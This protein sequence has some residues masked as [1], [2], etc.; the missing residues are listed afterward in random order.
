MNIFTPEAFQIAKGHLSDHMLS[1]VLTAI[2]QDGYAIIENI[3]NCKYLDQIGQQ[4]DEDSTILIAKKQWG[5]AGKI[6]GH[7][8]QGPP[9]HAPY[10]VE[11]VVAN[12]F[13]IQVAKCLLG[14][15]A[16]NAFYNG[17]TN[18]PGS[19]IQPLHRDGPI[20]WANMTKPHPTASI[21]V[22]ISPRDTNEE[23]GSV[24][25]WPGTHLDMTM[26]LTVG[27]ECSRRDICPPIRG[28]VRKGGVLIRDVRLWHRGVTNNSK[29]PRHMIACVYNISW[30]KRERT[31]QYQRGCESAFI[32]PDL[33]HNAVFVD[34]Q[35]D[36]LN[37]LF[38]R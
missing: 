33:D 29:R 30:L 14:V 5:G 8:Q 23:N 37:D 35:I 18:C 4:M 19:Q 24:E 31:L 12:P 27:V 34:H 21:V 1:L 17:N 6:Y 2:R 38:E 15:R 26:D 28:N 16:F 36:H 22:N 3:V 20:L 13:V 10:V 9:R 32:N 11:D 7:L 25:L